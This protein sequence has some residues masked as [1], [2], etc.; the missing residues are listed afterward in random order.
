MR[1]MSQSLPAASR[2][3]RLSDSL[4][5]TSSDPEPGHYKIHYQGLLVP[6]DMC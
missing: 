5:Q 3:T 4:N 6:G 2:R 1:F